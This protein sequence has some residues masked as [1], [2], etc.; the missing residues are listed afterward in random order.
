MALLGVG[1]AAAAGAGS[2]AA[3]HDKGNSGAPTRPWNQHVDAQDH[4]L[5]NVRDL[6]T[7]TL[8]VDNV[9]TRARCAD[10]LVWRDESGTLFADSAEET[11]YEGDDFTAAVQAALDGLTDGRTSKERVVVA[12][13]GTMGPHEWDGDVEAIDVPSHTILDLCG[14]IFVEDEGEA[15]VRPLR[16]L[17]AENIEIPHVRIVGN[18]RAAIWF[19]SVFNVKFGHIDIRTPEDSIISGT[20]GGVRIDGFANGRGDDT[21][22]CKDIQVDSAY[23]ENTVGH[24]FETYAVDRI[25]VGQVIANR[26]NF[27]G[28]LLNDT[29]DATV[30]AVVGKEVDVGGGYAAFRVANGCK[31]VTCDQVVCRRGARGVFGVSGC[32]DITVGEVNIQQTDA[33]GILIQDCQRFSINGGVVKNC[34]GDAIR[35]DSRDSDR[36]DPAEGVSVSNVRVV[37]T[38]EEKQQTNGI[39]ESGPDTG[40]NR[41]VDNDL[42]DAGTEA[43]MRLFSASSVVRDN[44][45]GGVDHG[46]V[47][48]SSGSTPAARVTGVTDKGPSTLALRAKTREP[49][50]SPFGYDHRFEWTGSQWDLVIEWQ[51]DPGED[52]PLDYIVDRPQANIGETPTIPPIQFEGPIT[53]GT[54]RLNAVHSGLALETAAADAAPGTNVQ[55]GIW[56]DT[57]YQKW[58]AV[59]LDAYEDQFRIENFASGAVLGVEGGSMNDGANVNVQSWSDV[60]HQRW[61]IEEYGNGQYAVR[62]V[63]SG[64]ALNVAGEDTNDGA[65][66]VQ[67]PYG[68]EGAGN[69]LWDFEQQAVGGVSAGIVDDFEDGNLDEYDGQTGN[70]TVNSDAP[71]A[72]GSQS[73]KSDSGGAIISMDGLDRYPAEGTTF[74]AKVGYTSANPTMGIAFGAQD[75]SSFYFARVYRPDDSDP[76][77]QLYSPESGKLIGG[78]LSGPLTAN[79]LYELV[80]DWAEGGE[81]TLTINDPDGNELE[82]RTATDDVGIV[83][84]GVG[85]RNTAILDEYRID[86]G[87]Q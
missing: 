7:E 18:F 39:Y 85:T 20:G 43:N 70:Y 4:D 55:Q 22:R 42:R 2:A 74:S 61:T 41:F 64:Q 65:N 79:A 59:P 16:A 13:S 58:T 28:V 48:L 19:R 47:T 69:E 36:H 72:S 25:Q 11:L 86:S 63:H 57:D 87:T 14:T 30:G 3:T 31:D 75:A 10:V 66:V 12:T 54:Y 34:F 6:S 82:S 81:F 84:G 51:T 49:P 9:Y 56:E 38:R 1:G 32:T 15:L 73:L 67:W 5:T 21:V 78:T 50:S 71:V 62:A 8:T 83:G 17:N 80:V 26:P 53:A 44:M 45:A 40:N 24:A 76:R 52:V 35:V 29:R 27:A 77:L 37:D 33:N 23:I 68:G 60:P 46:T